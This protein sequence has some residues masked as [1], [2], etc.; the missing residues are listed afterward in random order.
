MADMSHIIGRV[1]NQGVKADLA[2]NIIP[3]ARR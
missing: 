2:T 1:R 3:R